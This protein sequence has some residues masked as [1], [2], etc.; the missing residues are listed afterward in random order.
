LQLALKVAK[1]E[2]ENP[3]PQIEETRSLG[4][5]L[6]DMIKERV[7]LRDQNHTGFPVETPNLWNQ[8]IRCF[9]TC[10]LKVILPWIE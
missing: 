9:V 7:H 5:I 6:K 8:T 10:G 3:E 4:E 2:P 1:L